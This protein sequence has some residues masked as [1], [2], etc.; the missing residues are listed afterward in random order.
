MYDLGEGLGIVRERGGEREN[1]YTQ[2]IIHS[3]T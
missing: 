2:N 1:Y 3:K